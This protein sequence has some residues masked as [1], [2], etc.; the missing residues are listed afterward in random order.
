MSRHDP[1]HVPTAEEN[2]RNQQIQARELEKIS[3]ALID[4]GIKTIKKNPVP[5]GLYFIGILIC[6]FFSGTPPT[7]EQEKMYN[8]AMMSIDHHSIGKAAQSLND[9]DYFYRKSKGWFS[10]D[11]KCQ[12][13]KLD[14]DL[15]LK[16]YNFQRKEEESLISN[17]KSSVGIF[18]SIGVEETRSL[19]WTRFAQG[20][21]FAQRQTKWD[22]LFMGIS[23]MA[24]DESIIAYCLRVLMAL[25]LN[26]TIGVFGAVVAFIYNLYGLI[27]TYRANL[28]TGLFFFSAAAI[29]AVAFAMTWI[30]GLY[31]ATAGTVYVGSKFAAAN[32]RIGD[33]GGRGRGRVR[34]N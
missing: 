30:F 22:A 19:F 28:L 1:R 25:L 18:S 26:F 13:F 9:A 20:R 34:Y 33:D 5:V 11:K 21:E 27:Q 14:Y 15:A 24:K 3:T 10:C 23:A 32:M 12:S 4:L 16:E 8:S 31:A 6:L 17:A 7:I 29:S 2:A